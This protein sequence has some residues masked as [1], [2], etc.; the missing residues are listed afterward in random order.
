[1]GGRGYHNNVKGYLDALGKIKEFETIYQNEDE[2]IDFVKDVVAI[3]NP[4]TPIFSN[5]PNKIYVLIG[6]DDKIKNI[7]FY[8]EKHL[9]IKSI[10][11]D[12]SHRKEKW[13]AHDGTLY[14]HKKDEYRVL[15]GEEIKLVQ[16]VLQIYESIKEIKLC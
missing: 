1:M 10:H 3:K 9:M 2:K 11:L 4:T 16:K 6:K 12:H 5:S 14:D 8:S 13:H 7:S 15:D